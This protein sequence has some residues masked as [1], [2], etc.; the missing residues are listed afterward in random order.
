M[1]KQENSTMY[2]H[3]AIKSSMFCTDVYKT[4]YVKIFLFC[5]FLL[6]NRNSYLTCQKPRNQNWIFGLFWLIFQPWLVQIATRFT[7]VFSYYVAIYLPT[8]EYTR[9]QRWCCFSV[10]L[11]SLKQFHLIDGEATKIGDICLRDFYTSKFLCTE[12]SVLKLLIKFKTSRNLSWMTK[13]FQ[14]FNAVRQKTTSF[15]DS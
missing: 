11:T 13:A 15:N 14:N 7:I 5:H 4:T 1:T 12:T 2:Y 3:I 9:S 8:E 6:S 10:F